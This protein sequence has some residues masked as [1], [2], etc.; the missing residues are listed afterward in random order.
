MT[1]VKI[2]MLSLLPAY[3]PYATVYNVDSTMSQATIQSTINT[4][5]QA[6]GNEVAFAPG[7]YNFSSILQWKCFNGT[8][9]YGPLNSAGWVYGADN[10]P[11]QPT[12]AAAIFN[13]DGARN[14]DSISYVQ[15]GNP[16]NITFG[17]G[18]TISDFVAKNAGL[19]TT[20]G[21]SY[22]NNPSY[23]IL[24]TRVTSQDMQNQ[25]GIGGTS[26]FMHDT[27]Y[28]AV[29][30]SW[31]GPNCTN[32]QGKYQESNCGGGVSMGQNNAHVVVADNMFKTGWQ[33]ISG[34]SNDQ[35]GC[36]DC[37]VIGNVIDDFGRMGME[38][39]NGNAPGNISGIQIKYNV[40]QH[41]NHP[42]ALSFGLSFAAGYNGGAGPM[43][44]TFQADDNVWLADT[45]IVTSGE[46]ALTGSEMHYGYC[47][48]GTGG[49]NSTFKRNLCQ[50]FWPP[51]GSVAI[52]NTH[53][54]FD[55]S[56][57]TIHGP[58]ASLASLN[59]EYDVPG[60]IFPDHCIMSDG[61]TVVGPVV[62]QFYSYSTEISQLVTPMPSITQGGLVAALPLITL[63][64]NG[65]NETIFYTLDGTTPTTG[66][67]VYA[68]PF[69]PPSLP[70]TVN[71][72]ASWGTG[73]AQAIT[74]TPPYGYA[75]SPMVSSTFTNSA[76]TPSTT[77]SSIIVTPAS[78]SAASATTQ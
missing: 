46:D 77:Q 36:L 73:A 28:S 68:G 25:G 52:G 16:T 32:L 50:G 78:T 7:T 55:V 72:I 60:A 29:T 59:C 61:H 31:F 41:P 56:S 70:I 30:Q 23:G 35:S 3:S 75:P 21:T 69:Y 58:G 74:F 44:Y 2:M 34:G 26:I 43:G 76:V 13:A 49:F 15:G 45:P 10:K 71:A 51:V 22:S 19:V 24:I 39:T 1:L 66:S 14:G 20:G 8:K 37:Q 63:T 53:S 62:W 47:F 38:F 6:P 54:P 65:P 9:Y 33:A 57:T 5:D 64:A 42:W 67:K 27:S 4:A 17:S 11:M 12:G 48:E 18:C 40:F